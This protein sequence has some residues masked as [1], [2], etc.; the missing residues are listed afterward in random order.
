MKQQIPLH[1][2]FW[3]L[4]PTMIFVLLTLCVAACRPDLP[5]TPSSPLALSERP[6][7][8][9]RL[10]PTTPLT[11]APRVLRVHAE[12]PSLIDPA[13]VFLIR[14]EVT[15]YHLRQI[16]R[17]DLTK[18]LLERIVPAVVWAEADGHVVLAP[19]E[20]LEPGQTYALA[21]GEP[22]QVVHFDVTT[23]E[24]PPLLSQVWPPEDAPGTFGIFCGEKP[25]PDVTWAQK[26]EPFGPTGPLARGIV[27]SGPGQQCVRLEIGG[28]GENQTGPWM[29]PPMV[30][31]PTLG[32][33]QI[34][35]I[36]FVP[37]MGVSNEI[38][39]L[40]CLEEEVSFGPGC[41]LVLDDRIIV[42]APDEDLLWGIQGAQIDNVI[43]TDNKERFVI[44]Q[45]WPE[46][47]I[48]LDVVALGPF[49]QTIRQA[50]ATTTKS[51]SAHVVLNEVLANPIGPE[52]H[53][54]WVELYNDGQVETSLS[55]YRILDIGGET[56]L[57]DVVLPAGQF[58]VV[59]ND[60]F[61]PDDEV[62]EVPVPEAIV[63]RVPALGKSGL[64]NSGELLRL[65]DPEG[66]TISRFPAL[67]KPKAGQSVSRRTPY[68]PD[69]VSSSFEIT[70]PTPGYGNRVTNLP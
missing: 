18:T 29:L 63:V 7:F 30:E 41:G 4:P 48:T 35:P 50:F 69:G 64:S 61:V 40:E 56:V 46:T 68:A 26:L 65:V 20:V 62:D 53:Q 55:S 31:V 32:M 47:D 16:T 67:P 42:R 19:T 58:A 3:F 22:S 51:I 5:S 44:R 54:E 34:D 15:D 28:L 12:W 13:R 59:V 27:A 52:P 21:S 37:A 49:G 43:K 57:P 39:P 25:L 17:D 66:R 33:M 36:P 23:G 11:D 45:L 60:T 2:P 38:A 8:V 1:G 10:E 70:E 14:G 9:V 6:E 24:S